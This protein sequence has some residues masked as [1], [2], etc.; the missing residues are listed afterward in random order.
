MFDPSLELY[1]DEVVDELR[2][3]SSVVT[4]D[5]LKLSLNLDLDL[6]NAFL[7]VDV[8]F[9]EHGAATALEDMES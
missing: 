5:A 4:Q 1:L 6:A 7:L 8:V 2:L 9:V 3:E